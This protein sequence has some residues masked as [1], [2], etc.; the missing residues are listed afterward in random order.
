MN[1]EPGRESLVDA[2]LG[3]GRNESLNE[4]LDRNWAEIL[5][6]LRV[7][8][9]GTQILTGFLLAIAFQ[10]R[11]AELNQF[12]HY[13]YLVVVSLAVLTTAIGLAPVQLHRGLFRRH[14]K[15]E[16]VRVGNVLLQLVLVGVALVL[17]GTMLLVFD[18]VMNRAAA[19]VA[20]VATLVV[21]V[22]IFALP[23]VL[24]RRP[25]TGPTHQ[26]GQGPG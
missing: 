15:L 2:D 3:D 7:T 10:N 9:T 13:T 17:T 22:V 16:L 14:R 24:R 18:V 21:T 26:V 4:R 8:Q 11:F 23:R 25:E 20:A 5:Q 19:V 6:E 1:D 12:Q